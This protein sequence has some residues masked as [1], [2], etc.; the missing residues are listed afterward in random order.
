MNRYIPDGDDNDAVKIA[1]IR[2]EQGQLTA[3]AEIYAE[4]EKVSPPS[5]FQ[6]TIEARILELSGGTS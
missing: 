5:Q 6:L 4:I 3:L 1:S 2:A